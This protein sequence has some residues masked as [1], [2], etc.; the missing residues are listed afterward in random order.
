MRNLTSTH[1]I[2]A[3]ILI[4]I[5]LVV[6]HN[7]N[8]QDDSTSNHPEL[9]KNISIQESQ[10][11][12]E[13]IIYSDTIQT[14][15]SSNWLAEYKA[16]LNS[17]PINQTPQVPLFASEKFKGYGES[18]YDKGLTYFDE[19]SGSNIE[20]MRATAREKE[21]KKIAINIVVGV[22]VIGLIIILLKR[23]NYLKL[24]KDETKK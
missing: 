6:H 14:S 7:Y 19:M 20:E 13:D 24:D 23:S 1:G 3:A 8:R 10:T 21:Y 11:N 22:L 18:K 12:E 4:L 16:Y 5:I 15:K 2:V 9:T 17:K